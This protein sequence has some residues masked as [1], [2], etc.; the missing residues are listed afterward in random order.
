M[1]SRGGTPRH[2]EYPESATISVAML[3]QSAVQSLDS[4][5]SGERGLNFEPS[6]GGRRLRCGQEEVEVVR[7][8]G[9]CWIRVDDARGAETALRIC[10]FSAVVDDECHTGTRLFLVEATRTAHRMTHFL[11]ELCASAAAKGS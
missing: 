8:G 3:R 7:R 10:P 2:D 6:R 9:V 5:V 4:L 1:W 11:Q